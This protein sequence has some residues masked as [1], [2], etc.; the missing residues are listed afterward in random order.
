LKDRAVT[1]STCLI[2][3]ER[4]EKLDLLPKLFTA[5]FAPPA[6]H[7]ELGCVLDWL[8]VR[9]PADSGAVAALRIQLHLGE[10]EAIALAMEL[11]DVSII[12]DDGKARRIAAQLGLHVIG[13]LGLLIAAKRRGCIESVGKVLESLDR[14]GFRMSA[15][16]RVETL[17]LA[18]EA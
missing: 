5:V 6:V 12:L 17:R 1:N 4:I 15:G 7:D 11:H 10:A 3:L 8:Q 14:A 18:G 9:V 16:L 13:T 2:A